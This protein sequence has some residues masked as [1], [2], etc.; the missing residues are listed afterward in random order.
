MVLT[1]F[2]R[3]EER[4]GWLLA[5]GVILLSSLSRKP[6]RLL[7]AGYPGSLPVE[8]CRKTSI[9]FSAQIRAAKV[10]D[11]SFALDCERASGVTRK[12]ISG[13]VAGLETVRLISLTAALCAMPAATRA[14]Q[15]PDIK[16]ASDA[17]PASLTGQPGDGARGRAIVLDRANGNCL[18]CHQVPVPSE[19]FQGDI[20]PDL[21]GVGA[22]LT[23]GQI[24]LRLVDQ[25]RLNPATMMPPFYRIDRLTRVAARFKGTPVLP[26]AEI[27]DVVAYLATLK[28]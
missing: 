9:V 25:S 21:K 22:R 6:E 24:R 20:G 4:V 12:R 2:L 3:A 14:Q 11:N 16:I 8:A 7:R 23:A 1:S 17:I 13:K 10:P 27:E 28:D 26:A 18:I 5:R 19:P 15:L